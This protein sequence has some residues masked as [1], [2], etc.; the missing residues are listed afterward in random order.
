VTALTGH[1]LGVH[2]E[3]LKGGGFEG[4]LKALKD[5]QASKAGLLGGLLDGCMARVN[6]VFY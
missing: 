3:E 4:A 6:A 2:W 5:A 1:F